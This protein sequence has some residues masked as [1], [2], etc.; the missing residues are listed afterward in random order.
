MLQKILGALVLALTF[1]TG[2]KARE[3]ALKK[4][5]ADRDKIIADQQAALT[6]DDAD[7]A[8]LEAA[9]K[10]AQEAQAASE[11]SLA[12]L[13][14]QFAEAAGKADE[15]VSTINA[16]SNIP[17]QVDPASGAVTQT[18]PVEPTA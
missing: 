13:N 5:I 1:V 14:A 2:A 15:L 17:V 7:D 3:D 18:P 8:S 10:A 12:E 6:A 4:E 11:K 16:D 9:A